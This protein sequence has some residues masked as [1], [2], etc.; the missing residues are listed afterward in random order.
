M[1]PNR[2]EPGQATGAGPT[3]NIAALHEPL[4]IH[5][6]GTLLSFVAG[7]VDVVGFTALAGLFTAHVTGNFIMIGLALQN[8]SASLLPK[9]LAMPAFVLSVAATRR[10]EAALE[11]RGRT[12]APLLL[13]ECALMLCFMLAG[14]AAAPAVDPGSLPA[15][16]SGLFAVAAMGIQN[17]LSRTSLAGLGPTTIMTGNTTQI[18]IDLVDAYHASPE[19]KT[20]IYARLRKAT[21]AVLG[22]ASGAAL[23][24]TAYMLFGF[25]CALLPIALLLLLSAQFRTAAT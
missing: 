4:G 18:I 16:A 2:A 8:P 11:H 15:I 23:G 7:Y 1:P 6:Q 22:F 20:A 14:L 3:G 13:I 10:M 17:T 25:W 21:P 9:L 24:A 5:L 12:P 19:Q